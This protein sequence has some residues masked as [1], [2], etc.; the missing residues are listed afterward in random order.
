MT[1][2]KRTV[3]FVDDEENILHALKRSLRNSEFSC[4]F[5]GNGREALE[6][7]AK[8]DI[9]VIVTDEQ[10]PEMGGI[11]LLQQVKELHPDIIRI[12][13]S[14]YTDSD[15]LIRSINEGE[16]YRFISKPWEENE[17]VDVIKDGFTRYNTLQGFKIYMKRIIDDN[18]ELM[19]K[20]K[21]YESSIELNSDLLNMIPQPLIAV[22]IDGLTELVNKEAIKTFWR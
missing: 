2:Q 22:S 10:M 12:I 6:L 9:Q 8:N 7:I 21:S 16:I 20:M 17:L 19:E 5:S 11:E 4:M 13:L 1:E 18:I 3:L 15:R 14:G